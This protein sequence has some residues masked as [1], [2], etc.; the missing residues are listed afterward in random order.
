MPPINERPIGPLK[1]ASLPDRDNPLA[2][3]R[4]SKHGKRGAFA[5]LS[6]LSDDEVA[7]YIA[8]ASDQ[9]KLE[10]RWALLKIACAL[11]GVLLFIVNVWFGIAT[12]FSAWL[13]TGLG[14]ALLMGYWPWR[15]LRCRQ[16]W[17]QHFEAARNE[18]MRRIS[19]VPT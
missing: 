5:L 1:L 16:L 19:S 12:G 15:V 8:V 11:A 9:I 2:W 17:Q 4:A 7:R 3:K 18:Q 10:E 13:I 14:L 6:E